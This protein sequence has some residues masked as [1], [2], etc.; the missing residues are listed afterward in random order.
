MFGKPDIDG[1]IVQFYSQAIK[2]AQSNNQVVGVNNDYYITL[3]QLE[4]MLKNVKK[5]I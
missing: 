1:L 3:E 4:N 2:L 5:L